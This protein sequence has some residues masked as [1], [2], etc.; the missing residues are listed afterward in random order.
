M[1]EGVLLGTRGRLSAAMHACCEAVEQLQAGTGLIARLLCLN[2]S[3]WRGR[4]GDSITNQ[5]RCLGASC[6]WSRERFTLDDGLSGVPLPSLMYCLGSQRKQ[7]GQ[8]GRSAFQTLRSCLCREEFACS[9]AAWPRTRLW[10]ARCSD[11]GGWL[12]IPQPSRATTD[13]EL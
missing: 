9:V 4:Y 1:S 2:S 6:D 13:L 10:P 7:W 3:I 8:G 12:G 5:L 11:G